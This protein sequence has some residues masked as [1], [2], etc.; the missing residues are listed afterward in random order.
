MCCACGQ[1]EVRVISVVHCSDVDA[2]WQ[3][4]VV[5]ALA[6][7]DADVGP[8][9]GAVETLPPDCVSHAQAAIESFLLHDWQ[10]AVRGCERRLV[11]CTTHGRSV[12]SPSA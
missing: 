10:D 7:D 12:V 2:V 11:P 3:A 8:D 5:A 9:G 4:A 6:L 1:R